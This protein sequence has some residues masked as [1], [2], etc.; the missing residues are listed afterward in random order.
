MQTTEEERCD[1]SDAQEERPNTGVRETLLRW[2]R[3]EC[4]KLGKKVVGSEVNSSTSTGTSD[5]SS[6]QQQRERIAGMLSVYDEIPGGELEFSNSSGTD[7]NLEDTQASSP[8]LGELFDGS[9]GCSDEDLD[10]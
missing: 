8:G 7:D 1:V 4:E 3:G 9:H 6:I 2:I 10:E 5:P